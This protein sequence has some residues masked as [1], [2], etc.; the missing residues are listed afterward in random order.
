MKRDCDYCGGS[1]IVPCDC[2]GGVGI[3]KGEV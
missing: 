3:S 1:G 2:T